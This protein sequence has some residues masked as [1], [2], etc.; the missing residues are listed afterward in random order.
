MSQKN[1]RPR[2][3]KEQPIRVATGAYGDV[4][5]YDDAL[6]KFKS[7]Q[8]RAEK[9]TDSNS[10]RQE[11]TLS[12]YFQRYSDT[13]RTGLNDKMFKPQRKITTAQGKVQIHEF[14]AYQFRI[15]GV[16]A[17]FKGRRAFIGTACDASKKQDKAN[18]NTLEKAAKV[19]REITND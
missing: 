13:G 19:Y 12:R 3:N 1:G 10:V 6:V 14:K 4:Y 7:L 5:L 9:N 11:R 2:I 16:E 15:Y 17:N 18:V 8:D